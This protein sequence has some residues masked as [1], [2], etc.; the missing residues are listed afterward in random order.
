MLPAIHNKLAR[1][2]KHASGEKEPADADKAKE[3]SRNLA[4]LLPSSRD[5]PAFYNQQVRRGKEGL[6]WEKKVGLKYE[7]WLELPE[8]EK[9]DADD[10]LPSDWPV[11]WI[12]SV[13]CK[14]G[15]EDGVPVMCKQQSCAKCFAAQ[16]A[17]RKFLRNV[18]TWGKE[19]PELATSVRTDYIRQWVANNP[20]DDDPSMV[21]LCGQ[22]KM[23][24]L[25]RV[26]FSNVWEP[27]VPDALVVVQ[28]LDVELSVEEVMDKVTLAMST[29]A[30]VSEVGERR[31]YR[32]RMLEA[33]KMVRMLKYNAGI[34]NRTTHVFNLLTIL[35]TFSS[36]V[37]GTL[38]YQVSTVLNQAEAAGTA[39]AYAG[40]EW[41]DFQDAYDTMMPINVP[42]AAGFLLALNSKF[43]PQNKYSSLITAMYTV[44]S[45]IY[46]YRAKVHTDLM[47]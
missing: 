44:E 28:T 36:V 47:L 23:A 6:A 12:G 17:R 43:S 11:L 37:V 38:T 22:D 2:G 25:S 5:P 18:A 45:E 7:E 9:G 15:L 34:Q 13:Q 40:F 4:V 29:D 16:T 20:L 32:E 33:W 8:A 14:L 3:R 42:L 26:I 41:V 27:P 21:A 1:A 39:P 10:T 46:K 31:A 30:L 24:E 19:W 35:F